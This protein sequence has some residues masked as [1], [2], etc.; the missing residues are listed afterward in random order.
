MR[1]GAVLPELDRG[2][3]KKWKVNQTGALGSPAKRSVCNSISFEYCTFRV[4]GWFH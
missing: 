4:K 3:A 2:N 1:V